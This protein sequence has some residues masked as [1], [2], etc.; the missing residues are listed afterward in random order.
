MYSR[1]CPNCSCELNYSRKDIA[2]RAEKKNAH[3]RHCAQKL[4]DERGGFTRGPKKRFSKQET[5]KRRMAQ[6]RATSGKRRHGIEHDFEVVY[7]MIF[8]SLPECYYCLS[9]I[10]LYGKNTFE[11][12]HKRPPIRGGTADIDNLCIACPTCNGLKSHMLESEFR[13][14]LLDVNFHKSNQS[15]K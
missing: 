9:P 1:E 7:E 4:A 12:D 2:N 13:Q 3:C 5:L 14:F 8:S 15:K 11:M 6:S 10:D